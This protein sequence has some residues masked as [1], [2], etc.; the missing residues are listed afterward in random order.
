[1]IDESKYTLIKRH[2]PPLS[3]AIQL[4]DNIA[5]IPN[6]VGKFNVF[7]KKIKRKA[8]RNCS[9]YYLYL[10]IED[11]EYNVKIESDFYLTK[12]FDVILPDNGLAPQDE[13]V[14]ED[15][16]IKIINLAPITESP[17][18]PEV[19]GPLLAEVYLMPDVNYPFPARATLFRGEVLDLSSGEPISNA[20]I[21]IEPQV[22]NS[23]PIELQVQD[24]PPIELQ[25]HTNQDGQFVLYCNQLKKDD[26][27]EVESPSNP[28]GNSNADKVTILQING[29]SYGGNRE[30]KVIVSHPHYSEVEKDID[31]KE[32][33]TVSERF[34]LEAI[35]SP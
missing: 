14:S 4:K 33:Y 6:A 5:K 23:P 30:L 2:F 13:V 28:G 3:L 32:N 12:E 29:K 19:G 25:F 16:E 1:M 20:L 34:F 27:F 15:G 9:G 21:I 7:L 11:G 24:S 26:E 31:I 10:G 18:S 8:I 35:G 17:D 22:R